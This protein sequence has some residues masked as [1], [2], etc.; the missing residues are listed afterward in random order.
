[1]TQH[2]LTSHSL[3]NES[4]KEKNTRERRDVRLELC[5]CYLL[6]DLYQPASIAHSEAAAVPVHTGVA[7]S[8]I[9]QHVW[10]CVNINF[11]LKSSVLLRTYLLF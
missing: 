5:H 7:R 8:L 4:K 3:G 10:N 9:S 6:S 11:K 1:M 2:I